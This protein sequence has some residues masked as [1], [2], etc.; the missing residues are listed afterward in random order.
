MTSLVVWTHVEL[1]VWTVDEVD[2]ARRLLELGVR[3]ITTNQVGRMLS[4]SETLV[5]NEESGG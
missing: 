5:G 4:W 2:D 3:R 1:A